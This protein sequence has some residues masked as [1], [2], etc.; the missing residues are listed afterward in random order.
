MDKNIER[1]LSTRLEELLQAFPAVSL[2]GP[3]QSGKTTLLKNYLP[4]Y[5]YYSLE[6]PDVRKRI[7]DDPRFFLDS[8]KQPVI[9]DEAQRV[10]ELF[11]YLQERIDN[12]SKPGRFIL[13]GSQNFLLSQ[14]IQ[15]SLA[16]RVGV[17]RLLP[18]AYNEVPKPSSSIDDWVFTG[19]YPRLYSSKM[20]PLDYYP[21][22][23]QTYCERD[24]RTELGV[25]NLS[26]FQTFLRLCATHIGSPLNLSS[27]AAASGVSV[28]TVNNWLSALEESYIIFR[29]SSWHKNLSKRLVKKPKLY[30]W[31]TGLA[32]HLL[33]FTSPDD[34]RLGE[35][36]GEL[37]ENAVIVELAKQYLNAGIEPDFH[38]WQDSNGREID[39]IVSR[40]MQAVAGIEIKSS[41]TY[42]PE[43][44]VHLDALGDDFGLTRDERFLVYCGED[45]FDTRHGHVEHF[46]TI[47]DIYQK[48]TS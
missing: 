12:S 38:Y 35:M 7:L 27:L 17:L 24:V 39:L 22:Y 8:V 26:S 31:D 28:K 48:I 3:R 4:T 44:F 9:F 34:Y 25:R 19:S 13:S 16:G 46:E 11:S 47:A 36:K 21:S 29:L 32:C 5:A 40:G 45:T 15:Q 42:K 18:L 6:T 1:H 41:H 33:G 10:P 23:V 20:S 30:F 2:T 14:S 43:G 37:Y